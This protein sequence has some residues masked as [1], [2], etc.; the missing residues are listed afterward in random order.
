MLKKMFTIGVVAALGFVVACAPKPVELVEYNDAKTE[1]Q[2]A[3]TELVKKCAKPEYEAA[4]AKLEEGELKLKAANEARGA[5]RDTLAEQAKALMLQSMDMFRKSKTSAQA[6]SATTNRAADEL[7]AVESDY[8][9]LGADAKAK[10]PAEYAATGKNIA[11]AKTAIA[12]CRGNNA[13]DAL[14]KAKENMAVMKQ[15]VA[16]AKAAEQTVAEMKGAGM[17]GA[18]AQGSAATAAGAGSTSVAAGTATTGTTAVVPPSMFM[19]EAE[20]KAFEAELAKQKKA[21]KGKLNVATGATDEFKSALAAAVTAGT[22]K[23]YTVAKGDNL[24]DISKDT[25]N[26][27]FLWPMVYWANKPKIK[28]PDLIYPGQ[29]LDVMTEA[30]EKEKVRAKYFAKNR[31]PWSLFD[32]K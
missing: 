20:K 5:E 3:G 25:Y 26:N 14:K 4:N 27:P 2:S 8:A 10:F 11:D 28:D 21:G 12:D 19:T 13:L 32:G 17:N 29:K 23:E 15:K 16:E 1:Q 30:P 6:N 24:W 22:M 7:K 18:A 31:G 9:A